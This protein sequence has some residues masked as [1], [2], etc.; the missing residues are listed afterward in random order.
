VV[1]TLND[2]YIDLVEEGIDV[3]I[4]FGRWSIPA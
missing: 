1:L 3:A 4:R 2:R